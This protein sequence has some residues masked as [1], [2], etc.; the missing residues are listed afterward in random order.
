MHY[1]LY[2]VGRVLY[3]ALTLSCTA[4]EVVASLAQ[5]EPLS[6]PP[7]EEPLQMPLLCLQPLPARRGD[8]SKRG[9]HHQGCSQEGRGVFCQAAEL[10]EGWH[11]LLEPADN[12][13]H[14]DRGWQGLQVCGSPGAFLTCKVST[15]MSLPCHVF[16]QLYEITVCDGW[17]S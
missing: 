14:Q 9:G 2:S 7:G 3:T 5:H 17:H 12:D 15:G 4:A 1:L 6:L 10:Q 16:Q 11:A 8:R 13:A